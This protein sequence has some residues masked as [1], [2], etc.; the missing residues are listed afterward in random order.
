MELER[1]LNNLYEKTEK[2][3]LQNKTLIYLPKVV[4]DIQKAMVKAKNEGAD[5]V[6]IEELLNIMKKNV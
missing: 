6:K 3:T 2:M 1:E 4:S 5:S